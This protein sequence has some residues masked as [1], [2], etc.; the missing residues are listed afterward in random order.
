MS[1]VAPD[2]GKYKFQSWSNGQSFMHNIRV[3]ANTTG[4]ETK[5]IAAF[6]EKGSP[7]LLTCSDYDG[8]VKWKQMCSRKNACCG[9][10]RSDSSYCWNIYDNV[11]PGE[12]IQDV[13][14]QCCPG[15]I[16]VGDPRPPLPAL[17]Q[18]LKCSDLSKFGE[19]RRHCRRCCKKEN[20]NN[21]QCKRTRRAL[22]DSEWTESCVS[23]TQTLQIT[24]LLALDIRTGTNG[25]LFPGVA[26]L[27]PQSHFLVLSTGRKSRKNEYMIQTT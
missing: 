3:L 5:L 23:N 13:C 19:V 16:Q 25:F 10:I 8:L 18:T 4:S 26:L 7:S 14:S 12:L 21:K 15:D 22:T 9:T 1:V 17:A 6:K 27:L 2:Q 24:S 20:T 11:F